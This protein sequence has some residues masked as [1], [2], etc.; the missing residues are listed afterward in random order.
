MCTQPFL[1]KR[2]PTVWAHWKRPTRMWIS[3]RTPSGTPATTAPTYGRSRVRAKRDPK[4]VERLYLERLERLLK[5]TENIKIHRYD[6]HSICLISVES[7]WFLKAISKCLRVSALSFCCAAACSC[8]RSP[9]GISAI[10]ASIIHLWWVACNRYSIRI[11]NPLACL[12]LQLATFLAD[13][14]KLGYLG[15]TGVL[16]Y[17]LALFFEMSI[18]IVVDVPE[19]S[20]MFSF[21]NYNFMILPSSAFSVSHLLQHRTAKRPSLKSLDCLSTPSFNLSAPLRPCMTRTALRWDQPQSA[22]E[23]KLLMTVGWWDSQLLYGECG[24]MISPM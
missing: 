10:I 18:F 3:S 23:H 16:E 1:P 21:F 9:R 7:L 19:L 20:D 24:P 11:S 13:K 15:F 12:Y 6:I 4:R 2:D 22:S 17:A 14:A 8:G 5:Q